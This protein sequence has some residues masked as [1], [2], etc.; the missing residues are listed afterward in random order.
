MHSAERARI[1]S[2][3]TSAMKYT[4]SPRKLALDTASRSSPMM[5]T[6]PTPFNSPKVLWADYKNIKG[7][8]IL[9][10]SGDP[11]SPQ[12][13]NSHAGQIPMDVNHIGV[14]SE[15][16]STRS[17]SADIHCRDESRFFRA[18]NS[19]LGRKRVDPLSGS[20]HFSPIEHVEGTPSPLAPS[21]RMQHPWDH[22]ALKG[23]KRPKEHSVR[24]SSPGGN[25]MIIRG[26]LKFAPL[27]PELSPRP[28]KRQSSSP[29]ASR[30]KHGSMK[31]D[32]AFMTTT[33]EA[34]A[35]ISGLT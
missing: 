7:K 21:T 5:I 2:P 27:S 18:P 29:H 17:S 14:G 13:A 3:H 25:K 6:A 20:K 19:G 22:D 31:S 23:D 12:G 4:S 24:P 30:S 8:W 35:D 33:D 9:G 28:G 11:T 10:E 26:A 15:A 16:G 1:R 32:G 34:R